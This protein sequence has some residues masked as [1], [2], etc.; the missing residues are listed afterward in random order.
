M[1]HRHS[2]ER[3]SLASHVSGSGGP[4]IVSL[5]VVICP[6]MPLLILLFL[7]FLFTQES[8]QNSRLVDLLYLI[9]LKSIEQRTN[10][11]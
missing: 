3:S 7:L 5:S 8:D 11:S 9:E 1:E 2:N 6:V 4:G 10:F